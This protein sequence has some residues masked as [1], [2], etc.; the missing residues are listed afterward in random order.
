MKMSIA[1]DAERMSNES[2]HEK[3]NQSIG[4]VSLNAFVERFST[5]GIMFVDRQVSNFDHGDE[6]RLFHTGMS[7]GES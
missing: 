3:R 1:S 5:Q 6:T 2:T 7:L 4:F